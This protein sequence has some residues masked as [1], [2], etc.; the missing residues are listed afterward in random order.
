MAGATLGSDPKKLNDGQT[1]VI[2]PDFAKGGADLHC[3]VD[4]VVALIEEIDKIYAASQL[5]AF[6]NFKA[7][8]AGGRT[9]IRLDRKDGP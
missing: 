7:A 1:V 6:A 8:L 2:R 9:A 4:C 3:T 5:A